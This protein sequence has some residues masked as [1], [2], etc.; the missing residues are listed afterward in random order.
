MSTT[1]Y[2]NR[3][4]FFM[5]AVDLTPKIVAEMGEVR[6]ATGISQNT[7]ISFVVRRP[8]FGELVA[9][10]L[11]KMAAAKKR[12]TADKVVSFRAPR[13]KMEELTGLKKSLGINMEQ[14]VSPALYSIRGRMRA[15]IFAQP[16]A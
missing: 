5:R 2:D 13:E 4:T 3:K 12:G 14:I 11:G 1:W 6:E 15:E 10:G 8:D 16:A 7:L 9:G